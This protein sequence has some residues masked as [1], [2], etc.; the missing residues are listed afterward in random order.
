MQ[1]IKE[2]QAFV[3]SAKG[4][5]TQISEKINHLR[6]KSELHAENL[7]IKIPNY[8]NL[9]NYKNFK[10]KV[11]QRISPTQIQAPSK[12]PTIKKDKFGRNITSNTQVFTQ[13]PF[14]LAE[15]SSL[16]KLYQ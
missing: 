6:S 10:V 15:K 14:Q 12:L 4:F 11:A 8:S 5:K 16:I 3:K 7:N 1:Q 2:K 9:S 13:E